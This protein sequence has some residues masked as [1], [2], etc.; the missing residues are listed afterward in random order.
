MAIGD[1][2]QT[3]TLRKQYMDGLISPEAFLKGL[4]EKMRMLAL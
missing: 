2:Q 4:Q 3:L 1:E